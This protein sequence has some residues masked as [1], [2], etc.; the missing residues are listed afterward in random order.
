M[1]IYAFPSANMMVNWSS[2][3]PST[4]HSSVLSSEGL[5][6]SSEIL[7]F[8]EMPRMAHFKANKTGNAK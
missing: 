3:S 6:E 7:K 2:L 8:E 4:E 5:V 1:N